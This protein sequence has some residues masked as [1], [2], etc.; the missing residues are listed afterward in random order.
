MKDH[1]KKRWQKWIENPH[2]YWCGVFT[3]PGTEMS[4]D[5]IPY[6]PGN[7]GSKLPDD[8]ATFD[9]LY[10]KHDPRRAATQNYENVLACHLCNQERGELADWFAKIKQRVHAGENTK[11]KPPMAKCY[12]MLVEKTKKTK[13]VT[14]RVR[15]PKVRSSVVFTS[16]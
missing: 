3:N 15:E 1:A 7:I 14:I 9:H 11:I 5:G 8:G 13:A 2:C 6:F 12:R 4:D 16:T 10:D